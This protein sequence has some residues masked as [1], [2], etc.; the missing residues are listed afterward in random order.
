[1]E[2]CILPCRKC[3]ACL[4]PDLRQHFLLG[5]QG[6]KWSE[7]KCDQQGKEMVRKGPVHTPPK[8]HPVARILPVTSKEVLISA[9]LG[10]YVAPAC[11]GDEDSPCSLNVGTCV[12][13]S[14]V[15]LCSTVPKPIP[16]CKE[17]PWDLPWGWQVL[18]ALPW[19]CTWAGAALCRCWA[20]A[21]RQH[22]Q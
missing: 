11:P 18:A 3:C 5:F 8:I 10:N 13:I 9:V 12:F 2:L 22:I 17:E 15:V 19:Q 14:A 6:R 7:A 20:G 1:M 4:L 21:Q 16:K